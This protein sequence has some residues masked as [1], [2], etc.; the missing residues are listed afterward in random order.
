MPRCFLPWPPYELFL[1]FLFV[2]SARAFDTF[3]YIS[4]SGDRLPQAR[5]VCSGGPGRPRFQGRDKSR[6]GCETRSS[7]WSLQALGVGS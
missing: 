7:E 3:M 6:F 1:V 4:A 2:F 5:G